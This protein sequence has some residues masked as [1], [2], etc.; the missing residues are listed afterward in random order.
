MEYLLAYL[1]HSHGA[2]VYCRSTPGAVAKAQV[3]EWVDQK[4][5]PISPDDLISL[6][7]TAKPTTAAVDLDNITLPPYNTTTQ[8]M[9]AQSEVPSL[10]LATT[11][12]LVTMAISVVTH[13]NF[14]VAS[15]VNTHLSTLEEAC[16]LLPLILKKIDALSSSQPPPTGLGFTSTQ[17]ASL[18]T[19]SMSSNAM[20]K[21]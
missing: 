5:Q 21:T 10:A 17:S 9:A 16:A 19:L 12:Q 1:A 15:N 6:L 8:Q 20:D 13:K 14:T 2:E 18:S 7:T 3:M 4:N 11:I